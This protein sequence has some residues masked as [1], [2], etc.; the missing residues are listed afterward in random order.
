MRTS[1]QAVKRKTVAF[2]S[3]LTEVIGYGGNDFSDG[4]ENQETD[5]ADSF[6]LSESGNL[7]VDAPDSEE[8]RI[9]GNLT[10]A[11]TNFNTVTANL[12][13]TGNAEEKAAKAFASLMLGKVQ[14]DSE[15]KK[16]TLLVSVT[17]FGADDTLPTAKR[18]SDRKPGN[19]S[20]NPPKVKHNDSVSSSNKQEAD[21]TEVTLKSVGNSAGDTKLD[22]ETVGL[23]KIVDMPL[24]TSSNLISV[25]QKSD[26]LT[27]NMDFSNQ[28]TSEERTRLQLPEKRNITISRCPAIKKPESE[29][30]KIALQTSNPSG[31]SDYTVSK[32]TKITGL[33]LRTLE[34]IDSNA[35]DSGVD[36]NENPTKSDEKIDK[37]M[38]L[39]GKD[40]N[41]IEVPAA[42]EKTKIIG[43]LEE[44]TVEGEA[45]PEPILL[46]NRK[47]SFEESREHAGEP[48][49]KAD[50][51][52]MSEPPA[53]PRSLPPVDSRS[54]RVNSA[55]ATSDLRSSILGA[56]P[57]TSFLHGETKM[58]P[59]VPQKPMSL[60]TKPAIPPKSSNCGSGVPIIKNYAGGYVLPPPSVKNTS[61]QGQSPTIHNDP[62]TRLSASYSTP[63]PPHVLNG[64]SD[65]GK[66]VRNC[67]KQNENQS[68]SQK[69][70][71][72][73]EERS[74]TDF[75]TNG[76][77]PEV[78][79]KDFS[80]RRASELSLALRERSSSAESEEGNQNLEEE[81]RGD[82]SSD[83]AAELIRSPNK[84]RMAPKPP[85]TLTEELPASI[86]ARNPAAANLK[87]DCPVV[88]EKEKRE[89]ASSCSP[90]FR[91]AVCEAPDPCTQNIP[92]TA[93]RR[94][95]SLSQGSLIAPDKV[96]EK[97]KSRP[98]FSL[99]RLLRMGSRKDVDMTTGGG[100]SSRHDDIPTTPQ[101]K[102]RLEIIHPLELD[103][104]A[105]EVLRHDRIIRT[106]E[107]VTDSKTDNPPQSPG[108]QQHATSE[109]T[110]FFAIL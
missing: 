50:E 19:G 67:E 86:F 59:I 100:L 43:N 9:L 13:E 88:R 6:E 83:I 4:E 7:E 90:K 27:V 93:P 51:E 15:G 31:K 18:P 23:E 98:R 41:K 69:C 32:V 68:V 63:Q 11:N 73:S 42:K 52:E 103:G 12:S 2:P 89:R 46:S 34:D 44:R 62:A 54:C 8:D 74:A 55:P 79:T 91:K 61:T 76:I 49:G 21:K 5:D 85:A 39:K 14:K 102:P 33:E 17:P 99:K 70:S 82:I 77:T 109:F 10:R 20:T 30:P 97:K 26:A 56:E 71:N 53:L 108:S 95:I 37:S 47:F 66:E 101:P 107:D 78:S 25:I 16:K 64:Q 81:L 106:G 48:D 65:D 96:E 36:L 22:T 87:S 75:K 57:R 60:P 45:G 104:A 94:T 92:E 40:V 3:T 29:K 80:D 105:V 58:K 35:F 38:V 72:S 84:R 110:T 24:I 28:K 1:C